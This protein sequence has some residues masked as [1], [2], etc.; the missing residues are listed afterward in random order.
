[1]G[2]GAL[3]GGGR[4]HVNI[5]HPSKALVI[6]KTRKQS[7]T[8]ASLTEVSPVKVGTKTAQVPMLEWKEPGVIAEAEG[9]L[10]QKKLEFGRRR[11]LGSTY[12]VRVPLPLHHHRLVNRSVPRSKLLLKRTSKFLDRRAPVRSTVG[13]NEYFI[14]ELSW[15]WQRCDSSRTLRLRMRV[16]PIHSLC[17]A[18]TDSQV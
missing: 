17:S 11:W 5:D 8:D 4:G 14:L 1:M 2:R 7:S 6:G 10:V 15:A 3:G 9:T 18:N 12:L 13:I 16:C